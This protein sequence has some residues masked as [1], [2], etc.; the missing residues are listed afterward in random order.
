MAEP[1]PIARIS[2]AKWFRHALSVDDL[3]RLLETRA[4]ALECAR[5]ARAPFARRRAADLARVRAALDQGLFGAMSAWVER[6]EIEHAHQ[7]LRNDDAWDRDDRSTIAA[8]WLAAFSHARQRGR[9]ELLF[10]AA[11]LVHLIYD[12]PLAIA[13]IGFGPSFGKSALA[14]DAMT[15]LYAGASPE[16]GA[17]VQLPDCRT[18]GGPAASWQRVLRE[19]AWDDARALTM[20]DERERHVT[21]TRIELAALCEARRVL[22]VER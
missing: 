17:Q 15:S 8:P 16:R 7:Y 21:F 11:S 5:D 4:R 18:G 13:R 1:T 6:V 22:G 10:E 3:L 19:Q 14:Y 20:R 12:L 9:G 2:P